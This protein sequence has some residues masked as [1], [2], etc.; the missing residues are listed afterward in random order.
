MWLKTHRPK[1]MTHIIQ[2]FFKC[3]FHAFLKSTA[4]LYVSSNGKALESW[5]M[6]SPWKLVHSR[7]IGLYEQLMHSQ[8]IGLWIAYER[9]CACTWCL[10]QMSHILLLPMMD[11]VCAPLD[12]FGFSFLVVIEIGSLA[13]FTCFSNVD[14]SWIFWSISNPFFQH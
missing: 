2:F 8:T 10:R 12:S 9:S 1:E 4:S 11:L 7:T 3:H 13:R 6:N 14:L 5:L